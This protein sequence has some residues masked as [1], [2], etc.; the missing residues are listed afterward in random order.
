MSSTIS[1]PSSS[2]AFTELRSDEFYNYRNTSCQIKVIRSNEYNKVYVGFHKFTSY[3]DP[4]TSEQKN[5][6]NFVNLPLVAV[7]ELIKCLAD[8]RDFAKLTI[9]CEP[10]ACMFCYLLIYMYAFGSHRLQMETPLTDDSE[11]T[12]MSLSQA[13]ATP[14]VPCSEDY[15][16]TLKKMVEELDSTT[17]PEFN[18]DN[19]LDIPPP[20][21]TRSASHLPQRSDGR[22]LV[23]FST[24]DVGDDELKPTRCQHGR[25]ASLLRPSASAKTATKRKRST[26]KVGADGK[27]E[28]AKASKR[29]ISPNNGKSTS[30]EQSELRRL[31][32]QWPRVF[33]R[34]QV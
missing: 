17:M 23:A 14:S 12:F 9:R 19:L 3:Q 26:F 20:E 10:N 27:T 22:P 4:K 15:A 31:R 2:P 6:H 21:S 5:S 30:M 28:C 32:H 7:D 34:R 11:T 29:K 16:E 8:V 33:R 1:A 13:F 18:L 24:N 25:V